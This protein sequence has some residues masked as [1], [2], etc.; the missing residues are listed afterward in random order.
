MPRRKV[1]PVPTGIP[2]RELTAKTG[3]SA[4][5]LHRWVRAGLL[6]GHPSRGMGVR[7]D[8]AF[9]QRAIT[10]AQLLREGLTL[11]EVQQHLEHA[12]TTSLAPAPALATAAAATDPA[13]AS[14][15]TSTRAQPGE[16]APADYPAERWERVV[17]LPGLEL[18]VRTDA[19]PVLRRI[20]GE[21]WKQY[22]STAR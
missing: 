22:G 8:E 3:I 21:I 11:E 2:T 1:R 20:A 6:P 9:V 5:Q 13:A 14:A 17:L 16:T 18:I 12:A 7:Y 10:I 19:G 4:S 15:P